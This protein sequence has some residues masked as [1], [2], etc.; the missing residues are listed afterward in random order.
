MPLIE[1]GSSGS[2]EP[3]KVLPDE[4]TEGFL[5]L[6]LEEGNRVVMHASMSSIGIVDGGAGM[7]L[8]RLLNVLGKKGILLMPTFTSVTR[9]SSTHANFTRAGCW[10]EGR[11]TRHLP[12]ILELQPD[13]EIGEIAHRLC[14]WPGS[15]RSLH[16]TYSF[17]AVGN[18][19]DRFVRKYS[20]TDP[21]Q[22]LKTLLE[23]DSFVLTVG[24]EL[25][26]ISVI[27]MAEQRAVPRK[28]VKERAFTMGSTGPIWVEVV[29]L[30][31]SVGFHKLATH[32]SQREIQQANIGS[33]IARLYSMKKLL[34]TAERVLDEDPNALACERSECISCQAA[35][36]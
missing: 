11:E 25:D 13:K 32:I 28:Y 14:S 12:F 17:V 23:Q 29:A 18:D 16:P 8:H 26:S 19:S 24:V 35:R 15:R 31:C 2:P 36:D 21:L 1:M 9:H 10:C 30:G 4:L 33:A 22:P 34:A 20:L 6:G 7:V 3:R 5:K 27:H